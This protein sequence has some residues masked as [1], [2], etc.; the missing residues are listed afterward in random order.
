MLDLGGANSLMSVEDASHSQIETLENFLPHHLSARLRPFPPAEELSIG[1]SI[2]S[3]TTET[4]PFQEI[5]LAPMTLPSLKRLTFWG[6]SAYLDYGHDQ[7]V[8]FF[9]YTYV[10]TLTIR[11]ASTSG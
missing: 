6:I 2:P 8:V 1:F 11:Q 3:P 7:V 4:E 9:K 10:K 5:A